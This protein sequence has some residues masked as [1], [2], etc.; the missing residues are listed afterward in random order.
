M[1]D[2]RQQLDHALQMIGREHGCLIYEFQEGRGVGLER[3]ITAMEAERIHKISTGKAFER[4]GFKP[5]LRNYAVAIEAMK[6]LGV[7]KTIRI[8][9]NNRQ[10]LNALTAAGYKIVERIEPTLTLTLEAARF[11]RATQ[12]EL[13]Q[14]PYQKIR[15]SKP[16]RDA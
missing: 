6:R 16:R 13:G 11:V 9:T 1:C 10:K 3:K 4:L 15:I 12:A 5:D 7:P 14:I 2:C 8:I